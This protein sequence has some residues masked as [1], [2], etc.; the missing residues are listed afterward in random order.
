L[1]FEEYLLALLSAVKYRLY[2]ESHKDDPK[3]LLG[4]I[5]GDP[6]AEFGNE[7]IKAWMKTENFRIF[8]KFTDSH[9]F[10]IVDPNHPCTG[11]LTVEDV[12]RRL[13]QQVSELHLDER[14]Q[15]G[16]EVIGKHLATGQKKVSTAFNSLWADMEAMREAQRKRALE[17]KAA[18]ATAE[19]PQTTPNGRA[20]VKFPKAPDLSQAQASVAAAGQKAGAYFS[21][22][23]TW[24][25]ERRKTGWRTTSAT[26]T[27]VASPTVDVKMKHESSAASSWTQVSIPAEKREGDEHADAEILP[28]TPDKKVEHKE[29]PTPPKEQDTSAGTVTQHL[30]AKDFPNEHKKEEA[31]GTQKA[32]PKEPSKGEEVN[33]PTSSEPKV[34]ERVTELE[35][36][37]MKDI[38][39]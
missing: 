31:H 7:W 26:V 22:W 24:A 1:Q 15:S 37:G 10:D 32:S 28:P 38:P 13:A 39:L 35:K 6:V 2:A 16:K 20:A 27:P 23:G 5:D 9:I 19:S 17:Q 12:Q 3:A 36:D 4:D 30:E 34:L 11:G 18:G 14:F 8:N 29:L 25:S 33:S 21:S